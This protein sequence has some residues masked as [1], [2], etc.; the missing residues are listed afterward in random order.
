M[1]K[2]AKP[3]INK[4]EA[5]DNLPPYV[6]GKLYKDHYELANMFNEYFINATTN[7]YADNST[8]NPT[9]ISNLYSV[10]R[11]TFPQIQM[12]SVTT[13]EIKEI[14]KSLPCKNSSGY[15]EIPLRIL[16]ISMPF[17]TSPLTYLCNKSV[18][19]GSFPARLKYSQI[20]PI[21][22]KGD[23]T[24]LTNY[25]PISLLTSFSKILKSSFTQG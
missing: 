22:K 13:K 24:E 21:F 25:R 7:T 4:Q 20:I 23:K 9:A 1:W 6:D 17:I 15:D 12:A 16:K 18:S 14:I 3:E 10:Y 8:N 19:K 11:E 5:T 2:L